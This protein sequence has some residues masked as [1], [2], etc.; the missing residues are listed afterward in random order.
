MGL[1][2]AVVVQA[3]NEHDS[4]AAP[5]VIAV[6]RGKFSKMKKI[7]ADGGYRGEL[8]ENTRKMFGWIVEII[9]RTD[10]NTEFKVLPK[11]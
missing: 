4:I 5:L 9:L 1:L 2:L 11:R 7:I 3:A 8:I 10:T 6:I